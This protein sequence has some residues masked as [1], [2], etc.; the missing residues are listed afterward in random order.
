MNT[1]WRNWYLVAAT[2]LEGTLDPEVPMR[3]GRAVFASPDF[4][5]ALP[6][7]VTI[8]NM[9]VRLAA[10][11]VL[12][13]HETLIFEFPDSG[14]VCALEIRRG[15]AQFH[16]GAPPFPARRLRLPKRY[17]DQV[18]MGRVRLVDGLTD[19][20][21]QVSDGDAAAVAR[22]FDYFEDPFSHPV[23]LSIH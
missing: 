6:A 11:R 20:E 5:R 8:E 3:A 19:G 17:L 4:V 2:E 14:E 18:L 12:D 9:R 16:P 1:N 15:V 23:R 22:F 13:L 10:E 21:L 7:C